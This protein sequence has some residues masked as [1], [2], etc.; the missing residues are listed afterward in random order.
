MSEQHTH[1]APHA[2]E[3]QH[4]D[5]THAHAHTPTST[6]MSSTN[7]HTLTTTGPNIPI[8]TCIRR[9]WKKCTVT[10]THS[11]SGASAAQETIGQ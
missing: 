8:S 9:A 5:V 2:H 6:T 3:H 7:T 11:A 4:G 1:D 10:P